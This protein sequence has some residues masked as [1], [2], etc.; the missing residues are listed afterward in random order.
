M[1]SLLDIWFS[2][3]IKLEAFITICILLCIF[4]VL[5]TGH[6]IIYMYLH[7]QKIKWMYHCQIFL[8]WNTH[9]YL[10]LLYCTPYWKTSGNLPVP[11]KNVHSYYFVSEFQLLSFCFHVQCILPASLM[12]ITSRLYHTYIN[13]ILSI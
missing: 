7:K 8:W 5:N 10:A 1:L 2:T 12:S 13:S 6:N 11:I 3:C 9:F 4:V